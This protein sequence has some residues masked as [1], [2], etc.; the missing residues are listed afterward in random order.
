MMPEQE[1]ASVTPGQPPLPRWIA[2]IDRV[3]MALA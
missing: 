2:Q 3:L 1:L